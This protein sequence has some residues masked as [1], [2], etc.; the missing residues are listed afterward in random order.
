MCAIVGVVV[1]P[2]VGM[3]ETATQVLTRT[4]REVSTAEASD[5]QFPCTSCVGSPCVS[6]PCQMPDLPAGVTDQ[7]AAA[8]ALS[9]QTLEGHSAAL[10]VLTTDERAAR[11]D[12]E[13]QARRVHTAQVAAEEA[14]RAQ[15]VANAQHAAAASAS[16]A[17]AAEYRN[18]LNEVAS[19]AAEQASAEE[20]AHFVAQVAA[21]E[22]NDV[23][24]AVR[25]QEAAN[26]QDAF[27]SAAEA[28]TD[29]FVDITAT[30]VDNAVHAGAMQVVADGA[31]SQ[32]EQSGAVARVTALQSD[33]DALSVERLRAMREAL[34]QEALASE[35]HAA[36]LQAQA[37]ALAASEE[38]S[39]S[40]LERMEREVVAT[41][42]A[43]NVAGAHVTANLREETERALRSIQRT[44]AAGQE[45]LEVVVDEVGQER[46]ILSVRSHRTVNDLL[47]DDEEADAVSL[48]ERALPVEVHGNPACIPCLELPPCVAYVACP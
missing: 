25:A 40:A 24:E 29:S 47:L 14:R 35:A 18:Q 1:R 10:E 43:A 5:E 38:E 34:E 8:A 30:Y 9:H 33:I 6:P 36:E 2:S 31:S 39:Q 45:S 20:N 42:A 4:V 12:A 26:A 46:G 7:T 22:A 48:P 19:Q 11:H 28:A 21:N 15:D 27:N 32:S 17:Q 44:A 23:M 37:A 13:H 16:V 41:R 3:Q